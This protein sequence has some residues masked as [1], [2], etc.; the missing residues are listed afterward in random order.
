M[1]LSY[2]EIK[3][4]TNG[5]SLQQL[6]GKGSHGR[7]YRGTLD[8][9][10]RA[11]AVKKPTEG[12]RST[13][14][15]P[16][17]LDNEIDILLSIRN[18]NL[19]NLVGTCCRDNADGQGKE[20]LLVTEFMPNGSLHSLLHSSPPP[21]PPPSWPRRMLIALQV[22]LAALSL[23]EADPRPI[24][25]RDIKSA[26]VLFDRRWN[27]RLGDFS[28]AARVAERGSG[29]APAPAGTLGYLDPRYTTPERLG[30]EN[31]V[32]SFGVV[33]LELLSSTRA[34]ETD[35]EPA[36]VVAWAVPMIRGGRGASVCDCRVELRGKMGRLVGRVL[37]VAERCVSGR[38]ERRPTMAEVVGELR[39]VVECLWWRPT[40][41]CLR[42]EASA[43]VLHQCIRAW[44]RCNKKRVTKKI[45]CK[46]DSGSSDDDGGGG[47]GGVERNEHQDEF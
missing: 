30:P 3:A 43:S 6:I 37:A 25:H 29:A 31:D 8:R 36:S 10:K 13:T 1:E 26:N 45:V 47:G 22:A 23:H 4:S 46:V 7:V 16:P 9:G 39:G 20:K 41:G 38:E 18:P 42:S 24:V 12:P 14:G 28:L 44:K 19:V 32:F 21:R 11:V 33:L 5:F 17:K 15:E 35:R 34:M 27:A 2:E 40:W